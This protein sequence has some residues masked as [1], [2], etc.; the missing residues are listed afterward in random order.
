MTD[1][2][3]TILF[4]NVNIFGSFMTIFETIEFL[5]VVVVGVLVLLLLLLDLDWRWLLV[6]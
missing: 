5:V 4:L 6:L 3:L 2:T 1:Q